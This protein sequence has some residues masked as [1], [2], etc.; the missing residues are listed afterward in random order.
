MLPSPGSAAEKVQ[1]QVRCSHE[2]NG[3]NVDQKTRNHF[4]FSRFSSAMKLYLFLLA[5]A[6]ATPIPADTKLRVTTC[7]MSSTRTDDVVEEEPWV[8]KILQAI[9]IDFKK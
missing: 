5:L 1:L 6:A 7:S 3:A 2:I 4:F 9:D 8:P